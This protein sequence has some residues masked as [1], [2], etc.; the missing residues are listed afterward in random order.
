MAV[1]LGGIQGALDL[2]AIEER[3]KAPREVATW[4]EK[5]LAP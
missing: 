1:P 5:N 2:A 4:L 3:F